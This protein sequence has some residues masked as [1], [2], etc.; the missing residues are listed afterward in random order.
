MNNLTLEFQSEKPKIHSVYFKMEAAYKTILECYI[1]NNYLKSLDVSKIQYRNPDHFVKINEVYLG[2]K[3]MTA[4]IGE[5]GISS[6][7]KNIF[8]NNCLNLYVELATQIYKRF[9]FGSDHVQCLKYMSFIGPKN[10]S[11]V[12]SITPIVPFFKDQLKDIDLND[13]DREWRYLRN[14]P[15]LNTNLPIEE[16]WFQVSEIQNGNEEKSFPL[17]LKLIIFI[18]SLTH[19][20]AAV[21]R[22]FSTI[23]LNKTKIRNRLSTESLI[24]ILHSKNMLQDEQKHCFDFNINPELLKKF[25]NSMYKK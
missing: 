18:L 6:K 4:L 7:D 11:S 3:C 12:I 25:N 14:L 13:L 2:G 19:S 1:Q 15:N 5:T 21:E 8:I 23:N 10:I 16:F 9:P 20:T 17:L 22:I 24:G